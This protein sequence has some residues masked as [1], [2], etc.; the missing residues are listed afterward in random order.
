M[1]R[2]VDRLVRVE[3]DI[4]GACRGVPGRDGA[5]SSDLANKQAMKEEGGRTLSRAMS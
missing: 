2:G 5:A 3:A 1:G 4:P